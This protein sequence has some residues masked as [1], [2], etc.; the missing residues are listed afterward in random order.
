MVFMKPPKGYYHV[1]KSPQLVPMCGRFNPRLVLTLFF[2]FNLV[3]IFFHLCL[4]LPSIMRVT[5]SANLI[6]RELIIQII[7]AEK[8]SIFT[9]LCNIRL[10]A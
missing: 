2:F 1:E 4:G 5:C 3:F 9:P 10:N 6:H 7:F 8:L